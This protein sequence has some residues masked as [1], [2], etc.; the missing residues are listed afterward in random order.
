MNAPRVLPL[1]P[2]SEGLEEILTLN[3]AL[4][5]ELSLLTTESLSA[6]LAQ[7]FHARKIGAADAFLIGFDQTAAYASPNFLW[8]R[9]R[10]RNF[11][12]VDRVAVAPHARGKGLA[13]RLYADFLSAAARAGHT[14]VACEVNRVPP[15][16]ASDAFHAALGFEP[17]GEAEIYGGERTVRYLALRIAG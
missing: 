6:L 12:Y 13:R 3:N 11:A 2:A 7:A 17:V 10:Y 14:I 9:A 1:T 4:A 15:N 5:A 16:P 8:F